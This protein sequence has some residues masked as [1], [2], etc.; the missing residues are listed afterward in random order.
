MAWS[1][2]DKSATQSLVL[3]GTISSKEALSYKMSSVGLHVFDPGWKAGSIYHSGTF[4]EIELSIYGTGEVFKMPAQTCTKAGDVRAVLAHECMCQ[5]EQIIFIVKEGAYR[6]KLQDIDEMRSH[7]MVKGIKSFKPEGKKWKHPYAILG[8]GYNG[9]KNAILYAHHGFHDFHMFDRYDRVGGTAWLVQANKTSKLQTDFAAFHVWFGP[10]WGENNKI[11]T[12][13]TDWSS[14]PKKDEI[15]AHLEYALERYSLGANVFLQTD[16]KECK[17]VGK[18]ND[19]ERYYQLGIKDLKTNK[20]REMSVQ[21]VLHFPGAYFTPRNIVYPGEEVFGGAIGFGMADD[22]PYDHLAGNRIAILGNGAFAVENIRTCMEYGSAK[23]YQVCRKKNLASPRMVC[24]FVH[25][26]IVPVPA[27]MLLDCCKS[28][29][30]CCSFGDP[31]DFHSVFGNKEKGVATISSNSRFGIGDVTFLACATGRCEYVVDTVKRFTQNTVHLNGGDKIDNIQVV[32]KALGLLAD[33]NCDK[34][35]NIKE[36]VGIY[37]GGDHRRAIYCDAL[38]MHATNFT[39]KS[40][41]GPSYTFSIVAK[42]F[43]EFPTEYVRAMDT[44]QHL[45]PRSGADENKPAC[46]YTAQ[47]A[48]NANGILLSAVPK[49]AQMIG[50]DDYMHTVVASCY[51]LDQYYAEC[52]HSWDQYQREWNADGFEHPYIPYPYAHEEIEGWFTEYVDKVGPRYLK[53]KEAW[54]ASRDTSL[55]RQMEGDIANK[56]VAAEAWWKENSKNWY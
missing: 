17:L 42:Y 11:L 46:Q 27:A 49:L 20:E 6:K 44:V 16:V 2:A 8:A 50:I 54:Y 53:D 1:V 25:Q 9:V 18:V 40:T 39:T 32:I 29:Y 4:R 5:E 41:G 33:F 24:W 51:P 35:H 36:M 19:M 3:A 13:P 47:F 56:K 30:D 21:C 31:W 55:K 26:A 37:P 10:E 43:M 7:V 23:V 45:L 38:G 52:V 15:L 28:M 12:H 22:I 14:W 34:L 48:M